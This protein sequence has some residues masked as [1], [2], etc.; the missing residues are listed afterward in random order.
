MMAWWADNKQVKCQ[1]KLGI[2]LMMMSFSGNC[3]TNVATGMLHKRLALQ[4]D[5]WLDQYQLH[6]EQVLTIAE[7]NR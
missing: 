7:I 4:A 1:A 6:T 3:I 2:E 5:H